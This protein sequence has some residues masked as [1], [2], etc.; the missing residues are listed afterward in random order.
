MPR[1]GLSCVVLLIAAALTASQTVIKKNCRTSVPGYEC[2]EKCMAFFVG[3]YHSDGQMAALPKNNVL[4]LRGTIDWQKWADAGNAGD[5]IKTCAQVAAQRNMK[6][7]GVEFYGEC[8]FGN[9][10]NKTPPK[11]TT[12]DGCDKYC[13][14]DVGGANAMVV[15]EVLTPP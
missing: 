8:Y 5:L 15:Y 4:N 13:G 3:C 2:G 6:Y 10:L 11:V 7:F 12:V 9:T 1:I 14:F